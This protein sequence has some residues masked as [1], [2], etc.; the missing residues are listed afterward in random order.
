MKRQQEV[1]NE[2]WLYKCGDCVVYRTDKK[3][4]K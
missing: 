1:V 3:T 2:N 4:N